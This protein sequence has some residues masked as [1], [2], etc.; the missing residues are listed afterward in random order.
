MSH[1]PESNDESP[2]FDPRS[3]KFLD[4]FRNLI[5]YKVRRENF[6]QNSVEIHQL[7]SRSMTD[8]LDFAINELEGDGWYII[9]ITRIC[10]DTFFATLP[11]NQASEATEDGVFWQIVDD[12]VDSDHS[13]AR[14]DPE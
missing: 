10:D 2:R 6:D 13:T 9:S 8:A 11:G 1:T 4:S 12:L 5:E 14:T 7:F 3:E